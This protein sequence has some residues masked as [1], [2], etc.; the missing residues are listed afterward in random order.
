MAKAPAL[1]DDVKQAIQAAT[2]EFAV[3][4]STPLDTTKTRYMRELV[5]VTR[6]AAIGSDYGPA[7][8]GYELLGKA[9]GH[10][11]EKQEVVHSTGPLSKASD[12]KLVEI[13]QTMNDNRRVTLAPPEPTEAEAEA[14]L[15]G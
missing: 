1:P 11:V 5:A 15:Y 3:C 12:E 14:L 8:K 10:V 9:L 6:A 4:M 13:L 2:S 7:I